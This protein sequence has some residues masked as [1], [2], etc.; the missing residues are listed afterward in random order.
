MASSSSDPAAADVAAAPATGEGLGDDRPA[1]GDGA[2]AGGTSGV[3]AGTSGGAWR[4]TALLAAG[5]AFA[6]AAVSA[7]NALSRLHDQAS[8]VA[9]GHGWRI[10]A[11]ESSSGLSAA[12]GAVFGL[13]GL[14]LAPPG[15]GR[16]ARFAV[17]QG[18]ALAA[19]HLMHVGGF[20]LLR[21][22]LYALHGERYRFGGVD[23]WVYEVRKDALGYA[24]GLALC[25]AADVLLQRPAETTAASPRGAA[26]DYV[27]REGSRVLRTPYAE[28]VAA[29]SAG[30]YVEFHLRDGRRPLARTTLSAVE[31]ELV[32]HGFVRTHRSWLINAAHVR[33]IAPTG[34]G[35]RRLT[36]DGGG[37][38]P[39]SRRYESALP[40]LE[41][42]D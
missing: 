10:V 2:A 13:I 26:P 9:A 29:V 15:A 25:V 5:S 34:S 16:W 17:V 36:L 32:A 35:D 41:G 23:A 21:Q 38:A 8:L 11:D 22:A 18:L 19:F 7:V 33:E 37:E 6:I 31:S 14:R 12:A 20:V 39:L 3:S 30:N 24:V 28:I 27:I 1:G 42:R 4:R 40:Q